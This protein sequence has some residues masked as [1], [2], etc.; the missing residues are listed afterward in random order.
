MGRYDV[1]CTQDHVFRSLLSTS[2]CGCV[3]K[4]K[5]NLQGSLTPSQ[6]VWVP[7]MT[8][9]PCLHEIQTVKNVP[10]SKVCMGRHSVA[11]CSKHMS[12]LGSQDVPSPC[13]GWSFGQN[14]GRACT[15]CAPHTKSSTR[16]TSGGLTALHY[17]HLDCSMLICLPPVTSTILSCSAQ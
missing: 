6:Q 13:W 17:T 15:C 3:V 8:I 10:E 7:I 12:K 16:A 2:K 14:S 11:L 9:M 1:V 4:K 5:K